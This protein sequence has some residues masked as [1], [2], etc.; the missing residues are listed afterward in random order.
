MPA[1]Q[2]LLN[3]AV[4]CS[5]WSSLWCCQSNSSFVCPVCDCPQLC[6]VGWSCRGCG[7]VLHVQTMPAFSFWWFGEEAHVCPQGTEPCWVHNHWSCI[8]GK[9]FRAAFSSI[10]SQKTESFFVTRPTVSMSRIRRAGWETTRDLYSCSQVFK[11]GDNLQ[12][13]LTS[14][15]NLCKLLEMEPT[16]FLIQCYCFFPHSFFWQQYVEED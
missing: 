2:L 11:A 16:K 7:G 9:K 4:S 12:G 14:N 5:C 15:S 13:T 10:W 6:P 8:S 3:G 1:D